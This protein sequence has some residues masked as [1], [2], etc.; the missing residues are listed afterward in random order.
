MLTAPQ[1]RSLKG[2]RP[3]TWITAYDVVQAQVAE[4]A[5]ID[6]ILVG[7]S[8]GM[9]TLG[10]E[11]TIPV[12]LDDMLRH[13]AMVRRGAP[14]TMMIVDLPYLTYYNKDIALASA[15]RIM[16][17]T[18][19]NGVK[20][21][22]GQAILPVVDA[23]IQE[24]IPV[25]GHLGLT[26]QSVHTMGGYK[27]QAKSSSAIE[28]LVQDAQA[29]SEHGVSA[30]VLEG[31]PDRVAAYVT[32]HIE[33]PTIGIGAGPDVDGQVLV[34]HDCLGLS[35]SLP[36]FARPFADIRHAMIAGLQSYRDSVIN[37]TFPQDAESYHLPDSEWE[38]FIQARENS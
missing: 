3:I 31:I 20:L 8:L 18:L 38:K 33:A 7:D 35:S 28:E 30:I 26:P 27:V 12:T 4:E 22:G 9:T 6:V 1:L 5:A 24:K 11:S 2:T 23:L 19:A 10:Y 32:A 25:I 15:G 17:Q 37:R 29:L 16:Q 14:H 13:A 21:E 34:F 36:K